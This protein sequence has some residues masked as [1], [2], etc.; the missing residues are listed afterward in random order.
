MVTTEGDVTGFSQDVDAFLTQ[1]VRTFLI[2]RRKDGFPTAH[3]MG[4]FYAEGR[5]FLNMYAKSVKARN[6]D[7]DPRI[8]CLVTSPSDTENMEFAVLRG[9]ARHVP[10][11]ETLAPDAAPGL[12]LARSGSMERVL[13]EGDNT[14][15]EHEDPTD[16]KKRATVMVERVAAGTRVV[17]EVHPD[18]VA[19]FPSVR[20]A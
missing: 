16:L 9:R 3:P 10:R 2:S 14:R 12:R 13:T 4:R 8:T 19:L 6:L 7:S 11:D 1:N 15:F 17:W 18:L 5:F 20:E